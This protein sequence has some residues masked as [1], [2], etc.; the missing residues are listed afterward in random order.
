LQEKVNSDKHFNR[1]KYFLLTNAVQL[2]Q[3]CRFGFF[4]NK[5]D[6][7]LDKQR[8]ESTRHWL[9]GTAAP[10]V[11]EPTRNDPRKGSR[12]EAPHPGTEPAPAMAGRARRPGGARDFRRRRPNSC[13]HVVLVSRRVNAVAVNVPVALRPSEPLASGATAPQPQPLR[14]KSP[15]PPA[16]RR[17]PAHVARTAVR[18]GPLR[19]R[20]HLSPP[21]A[22]PF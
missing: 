11:R 22:S 17:P 15:C 6:T 10:P 12:R 20:P 19:T 3:I 13:R 4:P 9:V 18:R 8:G 5:S 14:D 16:G 1:G 2:P 21:V 7:N